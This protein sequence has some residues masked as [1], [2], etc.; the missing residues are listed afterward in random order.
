MGVWASSL[1]VY[2]E[3]QAF[4]Q[5]P[6]EDKLAAIDAT[7]DQSDPKFNH[8]TFLPIIQKSPPNK[9]ETGKDFF[10]KAPP[11]LIFYCF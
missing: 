6:L 9:I 7:T 11:A 5:V 1:D 4:Y 3:G 10:R 2:S 8:R